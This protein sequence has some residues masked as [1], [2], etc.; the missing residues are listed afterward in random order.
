MRYHKLYKWI[1]TKLVVMSD[2]LLQPGTAAP[3]LSLFDSS[4]T[5]VPLARFWNTQPLLIFFMRHFGCATCR[6]HLFQIRNAYS[7]LQAH[8][9]AVIAVSQHDHD[10]AA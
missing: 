1:L 2:T 5:A 6:E 8:G 7:A 9:G 3:N 4:G 10:L